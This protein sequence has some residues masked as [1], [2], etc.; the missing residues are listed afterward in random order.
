MPK[1]PK[2]KPRATP[3]PEAPLVV[4]IVM[5]ELIT[6]VLPYSA[7]AERTL[8]VPD[9]VVTWDPLV[10]SLPT[11]LPVGFCHVSVPS[12]GAT[13]SG[14]VPGRSPVRLKV[15]EMSVTRSSAQSAV[16]ANTT[17]RKVTKTE[18]RW[19]LRI[20]PAPHPKF[21]GKKHSH[22]Y[23]KWTS[24]KFNIVFAQKSYL[25]CARK[26]L[27]LLQKSWPNTASDPV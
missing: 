13:T 20:F 6:R 11:L 2:P 1:K 23:Y 21:D 12:S 5:S 14:L 3:V 15:S 19:I 9:P 10:M 26:K 18:F 16:L 24:G 25:F 27:Y 8:A 4:L 7:S 17:K 22:H